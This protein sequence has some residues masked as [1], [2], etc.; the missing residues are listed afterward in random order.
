M[1]EDIKNV[2]KNDT[3]RILANNIRK[4]LGL[5]FLRDLLVKPLDVIMVTKEISTMI[6]NGKKNED[7]T[8]GYEVEKETKEVE[9][10][11]REGIVISIPISADMSYFGDISVGDRIIYGNK[12]ATPFDLFKDS[13]LVSIGNILAVR[14]NELEQSILESEC[15]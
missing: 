15:K 6:P 8:N 5:N 9:S 1:E 4:D 10:N 3:D 7:G 11:F 14:T 13:V 12:G 2:S